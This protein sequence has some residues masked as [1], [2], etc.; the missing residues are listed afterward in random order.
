MSEHMSD[1]GF[2]AWVSPPLQQDNDEGEGS[3][4]LE[5]GDDTGDIEYGVIVPEKELQ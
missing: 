2:I 4:A 3:N 5:G 1:T